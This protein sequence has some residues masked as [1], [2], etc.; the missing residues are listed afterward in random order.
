MVDRYTRPEM[1][2]LWT[3]E[4]RFEKMKDVELA[5]AVAQSDLGIIPKKA[6]LN[7]LKKAVVKPKRILQIE[8]KTKH[9]VIA[10]VSQLA[11]EVGDDGKYI[12][13]GL[14]SSDVLDTAM[15]LLIKESENVLT[16]QFK[17]IDKIWKTLIRRNAK[18]LCPGRTH[19]MHGE[20]TSFGY[21]MC[22]YHAEF[23]RNVKRIKSAFAENKIC[24]LSGAVGTY[25]SLPPKLEKKVA[26]K[27]GLSQE[28]VATQVVPRDRHASLINAFAVYASGMERLAVEL[29]HLQRT[30]VAE[31]FEGFSKGQ[32]GSS[33]MPHKKNPITAENIT[34]LSRMMRAYAQ[35]S[36]ENIA[37]WH[38]RDISHSST[39][40]VFFADAFI[41]LHYMNFRAIGLLENLQVDHKQMLKNIDISNGALFSSQLL[42]VLVKAGL[43]REE[44]Y[45]KVQS[46][47]HNLKAGQH[48]KDACSEDQE[49]LDLIKVS[50]LNDIFSGKELK[51]KIDSLVR[52]YLTNSTK[53]RL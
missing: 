50:E 25:N 52:Q 36:L 40:R 38:E 28:T 10:F 42:L 14:T 6:A 20:P 43:S 48:L 2:V 30:E 5:V 53:E 44:A 49:V 21:K 15:S 16:K 32:K 1:G 27:L 3:P 31:A 47:S 18:K 22:G 17:E 8:K 34:G 46:L 24:K 51:I 7:I 19:G 12:H 29:R 23:R 35:T 9:D 4:M 37:L 45:S 13:F 26:K 41:L 11:E 33:A 39:E